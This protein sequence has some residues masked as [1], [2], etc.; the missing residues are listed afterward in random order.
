MQTT[1]SPTAGTSGSTFLLL[2]APHRAMFF[3][4]AT[5]LV[6]GMGWWLWMLL[7]PWLGWPAAAQPMPAVWMHGFLMQY[8]TLAPFVM[9]FL[10]T[11]FPR[12][13][14]VAVVPRR[15]YAAVFGLMLTGAAL[16][17]SAA[18][19]A[20]RMLPAGLAA[21]LLGWLIATGTLADRLRQHGF[22]DT[23]ARSAWCALAMGAAGLFLVLCASLGAPPAWVATANRIATFGFLLPMYF[24]V[25]H[26]MVPFFSGNVV[27]GYRVVRPAWSLWALWVLC[28]AHLVLD[29]SGLSAWR[30]LPDASL[31]ALLLWQW[32]AWQPWKARRPG[33]L[34]VLYIA[35]AWLPLSFL[36]YTVDSL[37]VLATG[38]DSR[39]VAPLH[40][41]TI[42]FFS[43]M[44]VAMVT[45][46]TH[47]H[48]G[49]PLA[50]GAIPWLAFLGMQLTALIR[51]AAEYTTQPW[52]WYIAAATLWLLALIPWVAR[53]LWIYLTPRR[54]GAPG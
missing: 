2:A 50:M 16:V 7:A 35:L 5:L 20:P 38:I 9:G 28:L 22:R 23:W 45:R 43:A 6:T 26:R 51:V 27:P 40:A 48:S 54:D 46:V 47:G 31:T 3:I 8:V 39:A 52:P 53:S 49:R 36:L 15:V 44:L 14:N 37:H 1:P 41:L 18:C 33:L 11:V 10:L 25:A 42:G 24:T 19:G 34:L 13:M 21:M 29:L 30:W 12:W 17:L 32:V 4:G